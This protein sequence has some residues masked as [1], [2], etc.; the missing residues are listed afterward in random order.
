MKKEYAIYWVAFKI[1]LKKNNKVLFLTDSWRG[2]LDLPGGRADDNEGK[3]PIEKILQ[4]EV[5][6]ELGEDIKYALGKP[7]FQFRRHNIKKK[8]YN[9]ITVYEAKYL[10][11][12]VNLSSEHSRYEWIDFENY[13]FKEI[14]FHNKVE[15]EVF[16]KYFKK[17]KT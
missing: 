3:I 15:Y 8:I 16:R 11:G 7:L 10:S 1:L 9:L 14:Y 5:K 2:F 13:K 4:R 6:E 12:A 17:L